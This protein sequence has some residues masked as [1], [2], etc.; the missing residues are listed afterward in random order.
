MTAVQLLVGTPK[1]AFI[2][3]SDERAAGLDDARSAVRGLAD[4][5]P[6]R[7]ARH[8]ARSWPA[9]GSPWYG[10]AVWRSEDLRRD[11][12]PLVGRD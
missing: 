12:D 10:P 5:R 11:L 2:L 3:E 7:R 1:G 6:H 8:A 4:P 9:G